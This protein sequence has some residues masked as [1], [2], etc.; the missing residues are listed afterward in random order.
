MSELFGVDY[1]I[2][3]VVA[4]VDMKPSQEFIKYIA[5]GYLGDFFMQLSVIQENYIQT[6]KKGLLCI[7]D[8]KQ[9]FR[10]SINKVYLDT[11]EIIKEQE[12][13]YEYQI[14]SN[15]GFDI[16]LS[17]WRK[18]PML[19][20]T[21]F[22]TTYS[23]EYGIS[24]GLHKWLNLPHNEQWKDVILI[25]TVDYRSHESIDLQNIKRKYPECSLVFISIFEEHYKHFLY[26]TPQHSNEVIYYCP[27]SLLDTAIA[28]HSCRLFIGVPSGLL[29]IAYSCHHKSITIPIH[30][31]LENLISSNMEFLNTNYTFD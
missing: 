4:T 19:C 23:L 29:S 26:T 15:D 9:D 13:I 20:K 30:S 8:I 22:A 31:N 17:S 28:I 5:G 7:T 21:N 18:H 12:Y 3:K 2:N 14:Y 27:N 16:D 25:N 11:Y 10:N 24:W 6:G 1:V